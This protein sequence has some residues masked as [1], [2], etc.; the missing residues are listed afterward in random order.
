MSF[1]SI[2][3]FSRLGTFGAPGREIG[4][5]KEIKQRSKQSK[6]IEER[7][8]F[9]FFLIA[10]IVHTLEKESAYLMEIEDIQMQIQSHRCQLKVEELE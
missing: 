4:L 9:V 10:E 3:R 6:R 2:F 7:K 5:S 8:E 1:E